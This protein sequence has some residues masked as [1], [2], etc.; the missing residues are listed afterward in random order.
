MKYHLK[1]Y[2]LS[3][4][5]GSYKAELH[6]GDTYNLDQLI[7]YMAGQN[8]GVSKAQCA[9]VMEVLTQSVIEILKMGGSI[10]TP[11]FKAS[12]HVK[13]LFETQHQKFDAKQHS[14]QASFTAGIKVKK[15]MQK[16]SPERTTKELVKPEIKRVNDVQSNTQD[17]KLSLGGLCILSGYRI[18]VNQSQIDEGIFLI[19]SRTLEE[20]KI[21]NLIENIPSS[22]YVIIPKGLDK[23]SWRLEIRARMRN[24]HELR[25]GIFK[26]LLDID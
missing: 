13:G 8:K 20:V 22:I 16:V 24:S 17:S 25:I 1:P 7:D 26:N 2:T 9:A 15:A 12:L 4:N 21:E 18:K 11:L 14:V 23:G 19:N 3:K 6:Q 10:N 5:K